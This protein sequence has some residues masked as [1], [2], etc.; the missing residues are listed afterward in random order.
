MR[1]IKF[2][3]DSLLN[4]DPLRNM[5][6][7]EKKISDIARISCSS[8]DL[9]LEFKF[10]DSSSETITDIID[11]SIPESTKATSPTLSVVNPNSFLAK[12][13]N[14][15]QRWKVEEADLAFRKYECLSPED[16]DSIVK[17]IFR[18]SYNTGFYSSF[19]HQY[20]V[21][22]NS[23]N[24]KSFVLWKLSIDGILVLDNLF[25]KEEIT[26]SKI[27]SIRVLQKDTFVLKLLVCSSY[28]QFLQTHSLA[29]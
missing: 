5:I 10:N 9:F 1:T 14:K 4:I 6:K 19:R 2:T 15:Y 12:L 23:R 22:D 18:I 7:N 26:F 27:E 25:I 21:K 17:D 28:S 3:L 8:E 13:E 24:K 29:S 20:M 11:K 16:R